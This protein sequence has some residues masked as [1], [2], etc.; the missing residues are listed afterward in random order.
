MPRFPFGG[1][2][3]GRCHRQAS[4]YKTDIPFCRRD[5]ALA[6][7]VYVRCVERE[8]QIKEEA[9]KRISVATVLLSGLCVLLPMPKSFAQPVAGDQ[10]EPKAGSWQ[11]WVISSG[12]EFR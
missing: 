7:R 9:M 8:R 3:C 5:P 10:I 12:R 1:G 6:T 2:S 4:N 11:T